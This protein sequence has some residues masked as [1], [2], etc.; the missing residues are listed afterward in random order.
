LFQIFNF[1]PWHIPCI[2][3]SKPGMGMFARIGLNNNNQQHKFMKLN[4]IL[5]VC[6]MAATLAFSSASLLAQDNGGGGQGGG[7]GG[8]GGG[9]G[10]RFGGGGGNFDPAQMQQRILEGIQDRLGFTNDT[11][12]SAVKPL[13]QSVLD[14]RRELGNNGMR[15]MFGGGR[16]RNGGQG[17]G[18]G[19]GGGQRG[20][21]L[22]GTPSPEQTALQQ[23]LDDNAPAAQVKDLLAKYKAT[24]KAKQAKLESAQAALKAVLTTRQEAQ[25]VLLDL[26][27]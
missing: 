8:G 7:N 12:W 11:D 19:G 13:V 15:A 22:F 21:G 17:G 5:T 3:G 20:G 9:G 10:R 24:Q 18:G 2:N 1:R 16:N 25:A 14:A 6:A 4:R 23:A 27:N 26:V